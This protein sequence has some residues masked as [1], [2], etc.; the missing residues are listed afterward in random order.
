MRRLPCDVRLGDGQAWRDLPDQRAITPGLGGSGGIDG[1]SPKRHVEIMSS[2]YNLDL[3]TI[4]FP[5]A[6]GFYSKT[7][8]S[9]GRAFKVSK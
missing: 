4:I 6:E 8:M 9:E 7:P 1:V 3:S 5:C 2:P